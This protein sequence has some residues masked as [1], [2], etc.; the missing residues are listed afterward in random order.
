MSSYVTDC[1]GRSG[2]GSGDLRQERVDG[3]E[4]QL[5]LVRREFVEFPQSTDEAAVEGLVLSVSSSLLH[6]QDLVGCGLEGLGQPDEQSA[7]EAQ[8]SPLVLG[9][10]GL[11]DAEPLGDL[12]LAQPASLADFLKTLPEGLVVGQRDQRWRLGGGFAHEP[13][14][15]RA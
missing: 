12:D 15:G 3:P 9:D 4:E 13:S 10:E 11:V 1:R 7:M 2:W 6:G 8:V 14:I 5:L